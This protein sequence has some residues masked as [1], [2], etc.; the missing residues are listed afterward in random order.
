MKI[1]S[2]LLVGASK[3]FRVTIYFYCKYSGI[4][5]MHNIVQCSKRF[6]LI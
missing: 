4:Q 1:I 3:F 6:L 2:M 5:C